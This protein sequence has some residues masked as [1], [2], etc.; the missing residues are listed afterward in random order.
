MFKIK[1]LETKSLSLESLDASGSLRQISKLQ[2]E[3]LSLKMRISKLNTYTSED[4]DSLLARDTEDF[5]RKGFKL[6]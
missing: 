3:N 5:N 2:A 4:I 6:I 1:T